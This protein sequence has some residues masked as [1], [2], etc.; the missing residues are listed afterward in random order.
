MSESP[1][2][3]VTLLDFLNLSASWLESKGIDEARLNVQHM[4]SH[5]LNLDRMGLYLKFDY[6]LNPDEIATLRGFLARRAKHEPLQHILGF[7]H[8]LDFKVRVNRN[9]LIPRPETEE[10]ADL[11]IKSLKSYPKLNILEIGTGSGVIPIALAKGLSTPSILTL[12]VSDS[13]IETAKLNFLENGVSDSISVLCT[14]FLSWTTE[15]TF[16]VLISNPPYI[17]AAEIESLEP[18]VKVFEPQFALTDGKD[19]LTFYKAIAEFCLSGLKPG[20]FVFLELHAGLSEQIKT[21]FLPILSEVEIVNDMQGKP[22]IL[23]GKK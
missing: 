23:K 8:F 13:A 2:Q 18:E 5:I 22:R 6:P 7:V 9:V 4:L 14:D 10:L 1:H 16:D 20:G 11:A 3:P 12:D 19:G 21:F 17:P 15:Q